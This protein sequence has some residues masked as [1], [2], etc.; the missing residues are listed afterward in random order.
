MNINNIYNSMPYDVQKVLFTLYCKKLYRKRYGEKYEH[1]CKSLETVEK[2]S[3]EELRAYQ[4]DKLKLLIEHCYNTVPYYNRIMTERKLKP[5]DIST[6]DDLDK[7]P[8]LTRQ[9]VLM[10]GKEMISSRYSVKQ[11]I[12]G[13]TSGTTGS[14]LNFYWDHNMW[15]MN[16]IFDWR[17]KRWAGM[18]LGDPYGVLLG[19]TIVPVKR[20]KPPFWQHNKYENQTWFSSFHLSEAYIREIYNEVTRFQ[21]LFLEGYPSTLYV[22]AKL[23]EQFGLRHNLKAAFTSSETLLASQRELIEQTFSCNVFDYY[24]SAE[25]VIWAT[26]CFCHNGKHLSMDYGITEIVDEQNKS[27]AHGDEGYLVGT[28]ILN[29][30]MPFIRYKIG[31]KSSVNMSSCGCGSHMPIMGNVSTKQEDIVVTPSGRHISGSVLTHPFK[32]LD[33]IMMSQI[34]QDEPDHIVV[35]LVVNNDKFSNKDSDQLVTALSERLG[36]EIR[37]DISIVKDIERE[38]SGKFKWV[39]SKVKHK[40]E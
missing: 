19:R 4:S 18:K 23:F 3:Y 21:P 11:L 8:I 35:K 1:A 36:G 22:L 33:S 38:K 31:D 39:K 9:D 7:L 16:N 25:R 27:L 14:P 13:H 26:E 10:H 20:N 28:S 15:F 2:Y 12:H 32:P 24:G 37:I 30:G 17:Q 34:V 6:V 5:S 29:Y 40:A